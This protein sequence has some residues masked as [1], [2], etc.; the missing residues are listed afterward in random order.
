[1][2]SDLKG[3]FRYTYHPPS[4]RPIAL[5]DAGWADEVPENIKICRPPY[6]LECLEPSEVLLGLHATGWSFGVDLYGELQA[7]KG[8]EML[9]LKAGI[10]LSCGVVSEA[11]VRYL[12]A[13]LLIAADEREAG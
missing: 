4:P 2:L 10:Q 6:F 8:H 13:Y 1:M 11:D 9:A 5:V 3:I 12:D 7:R